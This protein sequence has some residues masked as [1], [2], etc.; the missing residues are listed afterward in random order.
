MA[1][2][3][4]S[5]DALILEPQNVEAPAEVQNSQDPQEVSAE[6]T[7]LAFDDPII[8]PQDLAPL[9]PLASSD[10]SPSV[11]EPIPYNPNNAENEVNEPKPVEKPVR[12]PEVRVNTGKR[13]RPKNQLRFIR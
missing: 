7:V 3:K 8:D 12:K 2:R 1:R 6:G 13:H 4:I 9:E 5:P 11:D 10:E